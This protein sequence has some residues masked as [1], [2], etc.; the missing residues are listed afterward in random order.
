MPI[1]YSIDTRRRVILTRWEGVVTK[2][3]AAAHW[4][5]LFADPEAL[6][7][8]RTLA[9]LRGADVQISGAELMELSAEH[10][11]PVSAGGPWRSAMIVDQPVLFGITRQFQSYALIQDRSQVFT[12]EAAALEWL[13]AP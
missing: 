2:A 13:L 6:I 3:V 9:D 12:D 8:R 11:R 7:V 5:Q 1:S 10:I 4:K